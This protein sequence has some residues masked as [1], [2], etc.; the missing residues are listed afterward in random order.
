MPSKHHHNVPEHSIEEVKAYWK[1]GDRLVHLQEYEK[2]GDAYQKAK[3]LCVSPQSWIARETDF[4]LRT[5]NDRSAQHIA[6]PGVARKYAAMQWYGIG[7]Q[8]IM[9]K[10]YEPALSAFKTVTRL[11]TPNAREWNANAWY[12]IACINHYSLD[13]NNHPQRLCDALRACR[14]AVARL[15]EDKEYCKSSDGLKLLQLIWQEESELLK[16]Q[17]LDEAA[18]ACLDKAEG[19]RLMSLERHE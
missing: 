16:A 18:Q 13:D 3:D 19:L 11:Y 14:K 17:C 4:K 2:A 6:E 7:E 12:W 8:Y 9:L 15:N 10:D 1:I 5:L